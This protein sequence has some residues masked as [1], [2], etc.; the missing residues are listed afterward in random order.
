MESPKRASPT[1][2]YD[3]TMPM[4]ISTE[5][6]ACSKSE[7]S[8][9]TLEDLIREKFLT[10]E[11]RGS[12]RRSRK[13]NSPKGSNDK[14]SINDSV[15]KFHSTGTGIFRN[16]NSR[17]TVGSAPV[18]P[19]GNKF[20]L[21]DATI[22]IANLTGNLS[23]SR[24]QSRVSSGLTSSSRYSRYSA[25]RRP[26]V[27]HVLMNDDDDSS[28]TDSS[29]EEEYVSQLYSRHTVNKS[30]IYS[31]DQE[32]QAKLEK[33]LRKTNY[34]SRSQ[35]KEIRLS[36]DA[37]KKDD[38]VEPGRFKNVARRIITNNQDR[39]KGIIQ[40]DQI[41]SE[42]AK[43][44]TTTEINE[45]YHT[46]RRVA[47]SD[48]QN[49]AVTLR[50]QNKLLELASRDNSYWLIN[51]F[52]KLRFTWDIF[53]VLI[54]LINV[55]TI[56][57]EFAFFDGMDN[58]LGLRMFTDIWFVFDIML[59]FRTGILDSD[60]SRDSV[61]MNP[62][63]IRR[64]YLST[65][66]FIDLLA[67]VP[68]DEI[69][70]KML[71][72][73]RILKILKL[74]KLLRL[75]RFVRFLHKW[76][77]ILSIDYG[78]GENFMKGISWVFIM[79]VVIHWNAC[80]LYLVPYSSEIPN[81]LLNNTL[82]TPKKQ[83]DTHSWFH[84]AEMYFPIDHNSRAKTI[85]EKYFW[86]VFKSMSHMLTIGYGVNCPH[87]M[88]DLWTSSF[89]MF[90]GAIIFALFIS[91]IIAI[92]NQMRDRATK[93]KMRTQEV[94]DYL[95][96]ND[97]PKLL[98]KSIREFYDFHYQQS[99]FDEDEILSELN[100]ILYEAVTTCFK[101]DYIGDCPLFHS[102][103]MEFQKELCA[104][105]KIEMY[106][107][108]TTITKS[109]RKARKFSIVRSGVVNVVR[110]NSQRGERYHLEEGD[111]FGL[112][113]FA[114]IVNPRFVTTVCTDTWTEVLELNMDDLA[115]LMVSN[116]Q[117]LDIINMLKTRSNLM[118]KQSGILG[119]MV[120]KRKE[121]NEKYGV[122]SKL[123]LITESTHD[124]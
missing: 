27:H 81:E 10:R 60:N 8:G 2:R 93:F 13:D 91:Q 103:P 3:S 56:P 21:N 23:S 76:E 9:Q 120:E 40:D 30:N 37:T 122:P 51:P 69:G 94:E 44:R 109:G 18:K 43:R 124:I 41:L 121:F 53:T 47:I 14:Y 45:Y 84:K 106:Q 34:N 24:E 54:I 98:K 42:E 71:D 99:I 105:L 58:T 31:G 113:S 25:C 1:S 89:V 112:E 102:C 50:Q 86:S 72:V 97:S 59:N 6:L 63:D 4:P 39:L 28:T 16:I 20:V 73:A 119:L 32:D 11:G 62:A 82:F 85:L 48:S 15:S 115:K 12:Y 88:V 111:H 22:D 108:Y 46:Q 110:D 74:L 116:P 104:L 80:I 36:A 90:S 19:E 92:A 17:S 57:L 61:N 26:S 55:I 52:S 100:P 107:P 68:F 29:S 66:F 35:L 33:I 118:L 79:L 49:L 64:Q 87:I 70:S 117:F 101:I 96:F 5:T 95:T 83:A 65:W 38:P 75:G 114:S 67:T 77:E 123:D 7:R 78:T